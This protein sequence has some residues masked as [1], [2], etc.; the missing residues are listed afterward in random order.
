MGCFV[1]MVFVVCV[2]FTHA[3]HAISAM[4][5]MFDT[6]RRYDISILTPVV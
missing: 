5:G 2:V 6:V 3:L 4:P 1:C